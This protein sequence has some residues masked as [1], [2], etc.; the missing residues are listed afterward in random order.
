MI[1]I[2]MT[3]GNTKGKKDIACINKRINE[4]C[5]FPKD[6]Y[7]A[8]NCGSKTVL[9]TNKMERINSSSNTGY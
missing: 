4:D 7:R 1:G 2:L 9:K 5:L 8:S 3:A 6:N